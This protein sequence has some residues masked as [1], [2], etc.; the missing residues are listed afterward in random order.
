M[1]VSY[2][3]EL[4]PLNSPSLSPAEVIVT[5]RAFPKEHARGRQ[6]RTSADPRC[7]SM[8]STRVLHFLFSE[9]KKHSEWDFAQG[10]CSR[11]PGP[12]HGESDRG[13]LHAFCFRPILRTQSSN[14]VLQ[15]PSVHVK[16]PAVRIP[17]SCPFSVQNFLQLVDWPNEK[18]SVFSP[19][20]F[21]KRNC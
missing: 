8:G 20:A 1:F 21:Q 5:T 11:G 12:L 9:N 13:V 7:G 17:E 18:P 10:F 4:S 3:D 15:C 19:C 14:T 16:F 2:G 6:G